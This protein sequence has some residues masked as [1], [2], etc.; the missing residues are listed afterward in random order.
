MKRAPGSTKRGR[1]PCNP[2]WHT[3]ARRFYMSLDESGQSRFYEPSDW[4]LAYIVA[5]SISR[6]LK[7][8]PL[9]DGAGRPL[10]DAKGKPIMVERPPKGAALAAWLKAMSELLVSEG[11]RRRLQIELQLP[12]GPAGAGEQPPAPV[13]DLRSWKEG[14]NA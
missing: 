4:A 5:E 14:L 13:T 6:E 12:P 8:H 3:V 9:I 1:P 7:P 2:K 10:L 11:S